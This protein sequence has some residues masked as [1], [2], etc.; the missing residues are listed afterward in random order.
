MVP[1]LPNTIAI[2]TSGFDISQLR[3][4]VWLQQ[5]RVLYWGDIDSHGMEILA[6]LRSFIPHAQNAIMDRKTFDTFPEFVVSGQPNSVTTQIH[7]TNEEQELYLYLTENNL[8]LEQE[9]LPLTY[10]ST[11]LLALLNSA[12]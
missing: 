2:F 7:L 3:A 11:R 1:T 5:A 9:K 4:L 10:V 8:R 12:L 6:L